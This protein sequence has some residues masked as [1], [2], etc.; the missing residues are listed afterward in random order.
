M[1]SLLTTPAPGCS[2][3]TPPGSSKHSSPRS[4]KAAAW[5]WPSASRSSS[6]TTAASGRTATADEGRHS[7]LSCRSPSLKRARLILRHRRLREVLGASLAHGA[8]E[9]INSWQPRF[10]S[11]AVGKGSSFFPAGNTDKGKRWTRNYPLT[12]DQCVEVARLTTLTASRP[13]MGSYKY[14]Q[15]SAS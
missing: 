3:N 5:A 8:S 7:T 11:A 6:R 1:R 4:H 9:S 13:A 10:R 2:K 14:E 15:D 12:A